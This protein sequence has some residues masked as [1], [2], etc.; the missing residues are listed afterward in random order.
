[1]ARLHETVIIGGGI[2]GLACA[3]RLYDSRRPF[4]L[5]TEDVGG[6]IRKS[7]DGTVNLGAYYVRSDYSHVNRFVDRGRRIKRRHSGED[8]KRGLSV[9]GADSTTNE[10]SWVLGSP[11]RN[12]RGSAGPRNLCVFNPQHRTGV[13]S[14]TGAGWLYSGLLAVSHS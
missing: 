12:W 11:L 1:M 9:V 4:L 2:A 6:R 10:P 5:I 7:A 8:I 14:R 13:R 3:R